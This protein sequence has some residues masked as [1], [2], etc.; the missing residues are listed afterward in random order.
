MALEIIT[1]NKVRE[2]FKPAGKGIWADVPDKDWHSWI[3]QQQKRIK[4]M[5]QLEKVVKV[6]PQ[7]R[8]AFEKSNEMFNMGITPYY[9]SLL[10]EHFLNERRRQGIADL[11]GV[12]LELREPHA[13][14]QFFALF[15]LISADALHQT[16]FQLC[17]N[18]HPWLPPLPRLR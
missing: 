8:E 1:V 15:G 5:E 14:E 13:R 18:G 6:T 11:A 2:R 12:V 17:G 7:E 10:D 4:N 3:W 16:T 9:A